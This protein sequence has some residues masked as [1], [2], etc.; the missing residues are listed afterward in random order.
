MSVQSRL[1]APG[2]LTRVPAVQLDYMTD[3][4]HAGLE[5]RLKEQVLQAILFLILLRLLILFLRKSFLVIRFLALEV[6]VNLLHQL[7]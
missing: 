4:G 2:E 5:Y 6:A 7:I 3:V 1:F